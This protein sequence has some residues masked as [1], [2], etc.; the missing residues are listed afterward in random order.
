MQTIKNQ[1]RKRKSWLRHPL[2]NLLQ[3]KSVIKRSSPSF[4]VSSLPDFK[5]FLVIIPNNSGLVRLWVDEMIIIVTSTLCLSLVTATELCKRVIDFFSLL[6]PPVNRCLINHCRLR[7]NDP[8]HCHPWNL[9]SRSIA[10]EG[11]KEE[12]NQCCSRFV[13]LCGMSWYGDDVYQANR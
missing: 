3:P 9:Y 1:L 4:W 5:C 10:N 12:K 7:Q 13:E 2:P 8:T 6:G 11:K